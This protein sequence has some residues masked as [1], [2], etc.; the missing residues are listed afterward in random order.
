MMIQNGMIEVIIILL[1][2]IIFFIA[3]KVAKQHHLRDV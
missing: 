1:Y 2:V 3:E